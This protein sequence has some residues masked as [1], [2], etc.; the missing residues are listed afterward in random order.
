MKSKLIF[1]MVLVAAALGLMSCEDLPPVDAGT[2]TGANKVVQGQV[3]DLASGELLQNAIVYLMFAGV[4]DSVT[5]G[6]EGSFRFEINLNASTDDLVSV[7]VRKTGYLPKTVNFTAVSDT[8]LTVLMA[9]DLSTSALL[10]GVLR[11]S[12]TLY[13]IRNGVVLLTMPGVVETFETGTDGLFR[14]YA[15]L[16]D[17]DSM[18]VNLTTVKD[19]YKTK[20]VTVICYPGQTKDLGNV[21]LQVDAGSTIG[22]VTGNV[23]DFV[24]NLPVNNATVVL[25]TPIYVDSQ[26][27]G[28]D[29]AY[30]FAVN[31]QGLAGVSGTVRITKNGYKTT[32][33]NFT[34]NA[35]Q[36]VD[37]DVSLERDTTT[38]VPPDPT[39]TGDARSIAFI[40]LSANQVSVA[41]VGGTESAIIT[42]EVRDSLGFPID[43]DHS[44]TV[45]FQLAGT[46]VSGG[47]YVSP[48]QAITNVAGRVATTINSGTVSGVMQFIAS[49]RRNSDGAVI[50]STPVVITVNAGLP[51]QAHYTIGPRQFNFAAYNWLG[52]TNDITVQVGDKYSNPVKTGTAVYFNTTG[53]VIA[54]SGFTDN[55]SHALVE[56]YSGNPL[57]R[58]VTSALVTGNPALFGDGTGYAWIR[59]HSLGEFSAN[60]IDSVLILFSGVSNI[61]LSASTVHV[62]PGGCVDVSVKIADQNGNP[63]APGTQIKTEVVFTPPEG[64]N[65]SVL[66][67]GLPEDPLADYLT[68]G[69]GSTDFTLRL[70]DGTPGGTPS[71]MPF[72]VKISVTGPNGNTFATVSG[73]VGP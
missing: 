33:F 32:T 35:G 70:C 13:P 64:T 25:S 4:T 29:G 9:V 27:T 49:L 16:V 2:D 14:M 48:S 21:L 26:A 24:T 57:P 46:P 47:A 8:N 15:D 36:I 71:R 6:V 40:N 28:G 22:Q 34:V 55:T 1:L 60:V 11:D 20:T 63:L 52:R 65:W 68:R 41:G 58:D 7:Q 61:T 42:W 38:G 31:L 43:I 45:F 30:S 12:A 67:S 72:N 62:A 23:S 10:T 59:A 3:R 51:D 54:A 18:P 19:G 69:Q 37:R 50:T 66:G 56:L 44:D 17:R 5:T 39:G 53:G 73:D